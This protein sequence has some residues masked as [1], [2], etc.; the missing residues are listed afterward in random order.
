M[1]V[2]GRKGG[3]EKIAFT[4]ASELAYSSETIFF[5]DSEKNNVNGH[6]CSKLYNKNRFYIHAQ[7]LPIFVT[8]LYTYIHVAK[9]R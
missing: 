4:C 2:M 5:V 9:I 3:K 6:H 7:F 8:V 1:R